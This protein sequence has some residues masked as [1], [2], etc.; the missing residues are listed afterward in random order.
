MPRTRIVHRRLAPPLLTLLLLA[1]ALALPANS[2]AAAWGNAQTLTPRFGTGPL[3]THI[4]VDSAG[5]GVVVI[6]SGKGGSPQSI[7]VATRA[8]GA[9]WGA[10]V[11]IGSSTSTS[12][13]TS[14]ALAVDGAGNAVVAW[15][16]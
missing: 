5:D 16:E 8:A 14:P 7:Q 12:I 6:K 2:W 15:G 1:T 4:G 9:S 3:E 11:E 10:P 13:P